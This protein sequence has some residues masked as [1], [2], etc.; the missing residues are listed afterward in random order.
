MVNFGTL[1]SEDDRDGAAEGAD[2]ATLDAAGAMAGLATTT[3]TIGG[4][5]GGIVKGKRQ[6]KDDGLGALANEKRI[7]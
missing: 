4:S 1:S 7:V 6:A 3:P 2:S 5:P